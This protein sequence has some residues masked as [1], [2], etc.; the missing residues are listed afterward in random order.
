M[1]LCQSFFPVLVLLFLTSI[2]AT[3]SSPTRW[4]RSKDSDVTEDDDVIESVA[5]EASSRSV[6]K[7]DK[8]VG[9]K[10]RKARNK[11]Q[12]VS[13]KVQEV[14]D[15]FLEQHIALTDLLTDVSFFEDDDDK[16][17]PVPFPEEK[18]MGETEEI[19]RTRSLLPN[20]H[21]ETPEKSTTGPNNHEVEASVQNEEDFAPPAD[22]S[23]RLLQDPE[24]GPL[25]ST[26]AEGT[27]ARPT[28]EPVSTTATTVSTSEATTEVP[29][30][31]VSTT[32]STTTTAATTES[33]VGSP[34]PMLSSASSENGVATSTSLSK[35]SAVPSTTTLPSKVTTTMAT[36]T[37]TTPRLEDLT[38]DEE[39]AANDDLV[40]ENLEENEIHDQHCHPKDV[41][42]Q[43]K[44]KG[45]NSFM[46]RSDISAAA[47]DVDEV[48]SDEKD[49]KLCGKVDRVLEIISVDPESVKVDV[50]EAAEESGKK[51]PVEDELKV[52]SQSIFS[53]FKSF[54]S[55]F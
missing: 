4:R 19:L 32:T 2:L 3:D 38:I 24:T 18:D 49:K 13:D 41:S 17:D 53:L 12:E 30:T 31:T 37:S 16:V 14:S 45:D 10:M 21:V 33:T 36:T 42:C 43:S 40:G 34:S 46:A 5:E 39:E 54:W 1:L 50:E 47:T 6:N 26:A 44:N 22:K 25:S 23:E 48:C 55:W 9:G 29:S 20:G 35:E 27:T 51:Q 8:V 7:V 28:S 52:K 15:S 11:V